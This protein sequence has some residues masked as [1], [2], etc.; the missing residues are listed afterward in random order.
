MKGVVAAGAFP[1]TAER[2]HC[3]HDQFKRFKPESVSEINNKSKK[4]KERKKGNKPHPNSVD[5]DIGEQG[6]EIGSC[7][8]GYGLRYSCNDPA[9]LPFLNPLA[10]SE[11]YC[12][13]HLIH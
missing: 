12:P 9:Q 10:G 13:L 8:D 5:A 11:D 2:G 1:T 4:T 3:Q 7:E 6:I